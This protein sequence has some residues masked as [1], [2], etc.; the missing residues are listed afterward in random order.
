M[1]DYHGVAGTEVLVDSPAD[2]EGGFL[3]EVD[4]H[5]DLATGEGGGSGG[6]GA[7]GRGSRG[8]VVDLDGGEVGVVGIRWV[9]LGIHCLIVTFWRKQED[10]Q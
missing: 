3:G 10:R 7:G 9:L 1:Q 5:A 8:G 6:G 4:G 2:G